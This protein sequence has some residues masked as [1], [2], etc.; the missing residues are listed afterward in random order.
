MTFLTIDEINSNFEHAPLGYENEF[1]L[2]IQYDINDI[3]INLDTTKTIKENNIP[4][5]YFNSIILFLDPF[6]IHDT[7]N[8]LEEINLGY[9]EG[10]G[11]LFCKWDEKP[12]GWR[13]KGKYYHRDLIKTI[14]SEWFFEGFSEEI[15]EIC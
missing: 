5:H 2:R 15:L 13:T 10:K 14:N 3:I 8:D 4:P 7:N 9:R 11:K 12:K 1:K 6:I